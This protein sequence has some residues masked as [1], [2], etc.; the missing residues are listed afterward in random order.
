MQAMRY[1]VVTAYMVIEHHV[2][3]VVFVCWLLLE[4]FFSFSSDIVLFSFLAV[5]LLLILGA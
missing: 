2:A 5:G 4:F 1:S 3:F